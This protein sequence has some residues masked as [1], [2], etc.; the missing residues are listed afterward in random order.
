MRTE[1]VRK[2]WRKQRKAGKVQQVILETEAVFSWELLRGH[3]GANRAR[4]EKT[5]KYVYTRYIDYSELRTK[6]S[7]C[8]GWEWLFAYTNTDGKYGHTEQ[9]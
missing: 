8:V 5:S 4:S 3:G 9:S 6:N 2:K 7:Y 1:V